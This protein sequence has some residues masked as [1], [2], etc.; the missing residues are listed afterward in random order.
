MLTSWN[1]RGRKANRFTI[2]L[3]LAKWDLYPMVLQ[4]LT[5]SSKCMGSTAYEWQIVLS[6]QR[7]FLETLMHQLLPSAKR[8]SIS[9]GQI[10]LEI[11][12]SCSC[13]AM[14]VSLGF[15]PYLEYV[16]S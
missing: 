3:A 1:G 14:L 2:L 6:C 16:W 11:L 5:T 9:L 8:P 10:V 7:L 15:E 13:V 4:W 12:E